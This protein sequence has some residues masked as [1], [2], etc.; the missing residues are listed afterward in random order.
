MVNGFWYNNDQILDTLYLDY[1]GAKN[2]HVL[3]VF[4]RGFEGFCRFFPGVW[5]VDLDLDMVTGFLLTHDL[6][7][8]SLS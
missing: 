6:N 7:L 4:I 8:D 5:H 3:S 2:I 1:K